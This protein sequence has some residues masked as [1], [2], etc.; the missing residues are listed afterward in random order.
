MSESAARPATDTEP[1]LS[2]PVTTREAR[3]AS[4]SSA[5]AAGDSI[6]VAAWTIVSRVTGVARFAVI[7]AVLGPTFFGNT[8]QFTNSLPNLVY[9]GFLAGS[10]F[11]SLLVPALVRHIDAGDRRASERVAGGFLG[12]TLAA[13]VVIAPVAIA[14]GPL[15]LRFAAVGTGPHIAAAAQVRVGLLL[16]VMFIPQIFC[17]GIVGTATA[18]MN[19][20]QRFALAAAAPAVENIGTIAV[21]VA[22]AA[23][24]GTGTSVANVP[25]GEMLLLGLGSTA[26]VMLHAVTQWWGAR[27]VGVTLLPRPGWRDPEVRVV[28]RR[29]LPSLAQASLLALQVLTLLG[30]ANR[31]PG[32]IVAFQIALNFY[33]LAIA[34]GATPVALSLLPRL[35]RMHLDGEVTAFR[36][37]LVR[38]FALGFFVTIPAAIGYLALAFPLAG[39]VSFGRMSGQ[40]GVTMVAVS[41]AALSLAVVGQTAFMIATYASY[42]RND[43]RSPLRSMMIQ[44]TVCLGI[45]S[46]AL[47]EH[48]WA[49]LLVLGLGLSAAV[50]AA[51]C[52]LTARLWRD[53]SGHGAQRL[54][55]SLAKVALGAVIMTGP[56]WLAATT[57]S[58]WLA[59]PFGPRIGILAG[60]VVGGVVF[61]GLQ[62]I[63]RTPELR[64]LAA[65]FGHARGKA[66]PAIAGTGHG[67]TILPPITVIRPGRERAPSRAML[68]LDGTRLGKP[69]SWWLAGPSLAA[70]LG[71]GAVTALHPTLVLIA[72][73]VVAVV[74]CVWVHPPLA[75]YLVITL[76]PLTVGI[77]RGSALPLVRP[78]E[79]IAVL[80]GATL[81]ARGLVSLRAGRLHLVKLRVDR[82][83]LAILLMAITNSVV[84]LLWMTVRSRP[85]SKD[86]LL[87]AL[88]IWK[89]LG[90]YAIVRTS[91]TTD[92]QIRRC[93]WLSVTAACVVAVLAILQSLEKFGVT[94]LLAHYYSASQNGVT[95]GLQN[96]RGSSTLGLPAATADLMILNL[97]V[98][99]GLWTRYRRHR[100]ALTAAGLLFAMGALSAGEFSSAIGLVIGIVCVAAVARKPRLLTAFLPGAAFATY[101]LRPVIGRRLSGFQS[102]SGLPT[103]WTGRLQNLQGYFWPRLF[104]D[105]NFVLGVEPAARIE[106]AT[107]LNGYVWIES[108]YTW[109]LWGGGVPLLASYLYFVYAAARRGWRAARGGRDA[110]SVAGIAVF[111]TVFV[112]AALMAFDPHLTYRGSGDAFFF[113]LALAAPRQR[114]G[115]TGIGY[116]AAAPAMEV[117]R[118]HG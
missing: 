2:S 16:I 43:T 108:G 92:R 37:T 61:L 38:G 88:V 118:E 103:S 78:N 34:L 116:H 75:A 58:H 89:L 17:Y 42:A 65:G 64:L 1:R 114:L 85:I 20:R 80:A 105:W 47:L 67:D 56:A 63:W 110:R 99:V 30:L 60:A 35:A 14:I 66:G 46:I 113:M 15:V 11:S 82:V 48:G 24:Y 71:I 104:S 36:D 6:T 84:P 59:R 111:A 50:A 41:L 62:A 45:A 18:V 44:A 54:T 25:P 69:L 109:L 52:H 97:A 26:A 27:R 76:T 91:V 13:L 86:D 83:E 81:A 101:A 4:P 29:A 51:A 28:I 112:V 95:G 98:A 21:L 115:R 40:D 31:L 68:T 94:G 106:V 100:L 12:V 55:P 5:A 87:Y 7:G 107:Q 70:A 77:G 22:T 57:V 33:Y 9:Y 49:V 79:A 72:V 19:S 39:A 53:L 3:P 32:G 74:A 10:L 73:V 102:A 8:Y 96:G 93:L 90:L 117:E 23:I